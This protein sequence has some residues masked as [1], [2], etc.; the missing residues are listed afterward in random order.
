MITNKTVLVTVGAE[1]IGVNLI[2]ALLTNGNR[3]ICYDNFDL[4]YYIWIKEFNISE[5]SMNSKYILFREDIRNVKVISECFVS[6]NFYFIIHLVAQAGVRVSIK[7]PLE[8]IDVNING[9]VKILEMARK[10]SKK[11]SDCIFFI[12]LW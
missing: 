2:R 4:F 8:Y 6:F 11:K 5:F 10:K 12:Y 7:N 1:F 3:V 9:T